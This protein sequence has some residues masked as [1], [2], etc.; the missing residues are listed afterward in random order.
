M[1]ALVAFSARHL[2]RHWRLHL[3][4]LSFLV[5][6]SALVA[7][8]PMYAKAIA[9]EGLRQ[10]VDEAAPSERNMLLT[11]STYRGVQLTSAAY[12]D[13]Q[14]A[15]G[16][17]VQDRLEVRDV[18]VDLRRSLRPSTDLDKKQPTAVRL[19]A[20]DSLSPYIRIV[21]GRLPEHVEPQT[22]AEALFQPP[23]LEVAIGAPSAAKAGLA[24]G[25]WF[26]ATNGAEIR[27]VG[28]VEPIDPAED[29]WW[30]LKVP[31]AFRIPFLGDEDIFTLPAITP[32]QTLRTHF[33]FHQA[34]WRV[35]LDRGQITADRVDQI[36][37]AL[38]RIETR[39]Q[40]YKIQ[41]VTGVPEFL[42]AYRRQLATARMSL[43]LLSAQAFVFVLY[44]L[45]MMTAFLL[46]R[47]Q[48]ELVTL[49]G[50]GAGRLQITLV[51]A[52]E[53]LGMSLLAAI[54]LGPVVARAAI[55][56]WIAGLGGPPTWD[57]LPESRY[58]ALIA[59][60]ASWLALV[61]PVY[62]SSRIDLLEWQRQVARP[63]RRAGWQRLYLDLV[64]L[65][66]GGL[67]YWQLT[68]SGSFILRRVGSDQFADPILL[69]GPSLLLIAVALVFLRVFPY[70]LRFAS[71]LTKGVRGAILPLGLAR[72]S[73][74]PRGPSR[75]VLLISLAAGL[76]LFANAFE[77]S[78][79]LRQGEVAH[80]QAGADLRI[81]LPVDSVEAIRGLPGVLEAS[82]V[83]HGELRTREQRLVN[84][85]AVDPETFGRVAHYPPNFTNLTIP[86]VTRALQPQTDPE[87]LPAVLSTSALP[88][89]AEVRDQVTLHLVGRELTFDVR[90]IVVNFPAVSEPFAVVSLPDLAK[91]V[92]LA[93][94]RRTT[95][96]EIWLDV[97]PDAHSALASDPRFVGL[98]VEDA[99]KRF[100]S[101]QSDALAQ[102]ANQAF[103]LNALTLAVL[104]VAA[105]VLVHYFAARQR[106]YE[107]GILRAAG[108]AP[109]QLLVLLV[110][111]GLLV[112]AL[113]LL[114]GTAIGYGL[115]RIM[116]GYLS[117]VLSAATAGV[118]IR[119]IVI[120]WAGVARQ[121]AVLVS[122]YVVAMLLLLLVLL[123]AGV[124]RV[125]RMGEE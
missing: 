48:S 57:I 41:T 36:E 22:Q 80:Y 96:S 73:R 98:I 104:S 119:E 26:T 82:P 15:L 59:A 21:D 115:S 46:D 5:L 83:L 40:A 125:L 58:L 70:V 102:G 56:L 14:D 12:G 3:I 64:L 17:L 113:G 109:W 117:P 9:A 23:V 66:F 76:I 122:A 63:A 43:T 84:L 39:M 44:A 61:V 6:A 31:F 114:A 28:I 111:E 68:E 11:A 29:V 74:D 116:V 45:A 89:G 37:A 92:D 49:A 77:N 51:F 105:F 99:M 101:L 16:D 34:S 95:Q 30:G 112:M 4:I 7:G 93:T 38:T 72:L 108:A 32:L 13:L 86:S 123:R 71:W 53:F 65:A 100:E 24:V 10:A 103:R 106:T 50:R 67:I 81:S 85:M 69:L 79:A 91:M 2:L 42:A 52:V 20:F 121:Y 27:I 62:T 8:L 18:Q 35:L 120:G 19:Y 33:V 25:N 88:K 87:V 90:G 110:T 118:P 47:S 60:G 75:V 78:L 55:N 97:E 1:M 94:Q 107:F 54:L 124:H